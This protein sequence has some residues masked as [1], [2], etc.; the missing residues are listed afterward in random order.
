MSNG[1]SKAS[2]AYEHF[3]IIQTYRFTDFCTS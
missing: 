1:R 3:V 2:H